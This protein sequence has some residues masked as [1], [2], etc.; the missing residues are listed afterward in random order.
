MAT[1][2]TVTFVP[3][4]AP[5]HWDE[6]HTFTTVGSNIFTPKMPISDAHVLAIGG[7]GQGGFAAGWYATGGP[8]SQGGGA[9]GFVDETGVEFASATNYG[10]TVGKGGKKTETD[11][12]A[13][14]NTATT[15]LT[16]A[17]GN[18]NNEVKDATTITNAT[19]NSF[20]FARVWGGQGGDTYYVS[21]NGYGGKGGYASNIFFTYSGLT[22][23]AGGKGG[24]GK[25]TPNGTCTGTESQYWQDGGTGGNPGG[26]AGGRSKYCD[27]GQQRYSG[28]GGG[29]FSAILNGNANANGYAF[30]IA[31]GGGGAVTQDK[32]TSLN[33]ADAG[34]QIGNSMSKHNCTWVVP[35]TRSGAVGGDGVYATGH[36]W[37]E[38]G[39]GGGG[40]GAVG[41]Y[42]VQSRPNS[43]VCSGGGGTN[44]AL[45]FLEN[46]GTFSN[47]PNAAINGNQSMPK[48][49]GNTISGTETGHSGQGV[50]QVYKINYTP[51]MAPG[52]DSVVETATTQ[53]RACG[54]GSGTGNQMAFNAEYNAGGSSGGVVSSSS[55][56]PVKSGCE[57]QGNPGG[58]STDG[59]WKSPGGGGAGGA[60][61]T[62]INNSETTT[63]N[64]GK[65]GMGKYSDI[66]G[67]LV[68]YAGGG[69][70]STTSAT[71]TQLADTGG[72]NGT[73][74]NSNGGACK[75]GGGANGVR[76]TSNGKD[77]A[78]NTGGGGSGAVSADKDKGFRLGGGGG[79]GIVV[80]RFPYVNADTVDVDEA[81]QGGTITTAEQYNDNY[82]I[83][84]FTPITENGAPSETA[85]YILVQASSPAELAPAPF[86]SAD[87]K[88]P[89]LDGVTVAGT[90]LQYYKRG[91]VLAETSALAAHFDEGSLFYRVVAV[92]PGDPK[93]I[94]TYY[95]IKEVGT[96]EKT[97]HCPCEQDGSCPDPSQSP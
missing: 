62:G 9:G 81:S 76:T 64:A 26:G 11:I 38:T 90:V 6:V 78:A 83:V 40:G 49:S 48:P 91:E 19:K 95:E 59:W 56:A 36:G 72:G 25:N 82:D 35:T 23:F 89:V 33:G 39:T 30:A 47:F 94:L 3:S 52:E 60:G 80:I 13:A 75:G 66:T 67:A 93:Q 2:G 15:T 42:A 50:V 70:G 41:G 73:Q 10:V 18:N 12:Q 58:A 71:D 65:G 44:E 57:G 87:G 43:S 28:G 69:G 7:G 4:D 32:S 17:T 63:D 97:S 14:V 8:G 5:S 51:Y 34:V 16:T 61:S 84:K 53:V 96:H 85:E 37:N 86:T 92:T 1:G 22:Y 20:V 77:G 88:V 46:I 79:S 55:P 27:S 24:N 21:S 74:V 29:G 68:C 45:K 31:G 54:G